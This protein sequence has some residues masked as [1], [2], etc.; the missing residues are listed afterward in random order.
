[1]EIVLTGATGFVGSNLLRKL[2][3]LEY[4]PLVVL[5][6]KNE[7]NP[8]YNEV[9]IESID[10]KT[11][12]KDSLSGCD[13]VIHCAARVHMMDD[14]SLDPLSEFREVNTQG[15]LNLARSASKAGVK[16]FI[17]TSSIKV[18][19]EE[20]LLGSPFKS[21]DEPNP[22]DP[23]GISKFEAEEGL[24]KIA[25]E[26]GMDVVIIRPPL[27]YGPG[28][29][30]NFAS[31]LKFASLGIPLPFGGIKHNLRSLVSID[32]LVDLIATCTTHPSAANHVFLVSDGE[33]VSTAKMFQQLSKSFGKSGFMLSVPVFLYRLL[34][35][36]TGKSEIVDRLCGNLQVDISETK[37]LLN[38]KPVVT[39]QEGFAK[40]AESF[41][42][43][44]R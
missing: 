26:T 19:G 4:S 33:D 39:F 5:R 44:K 14:K 17:F 30:G 41:I 7:N 42:K 16:R 15:T 1:M 29:K 3:E 9:M 18:S 40:T 35:K 32:N 25:L 8:R 34:G 11:D 24:K 36:L 22:L 31:M 12:W 20:T 38:W 10:S 21:S 23:Y 43:N 27:V 13:V 6:S 28:V 2:V 37:S